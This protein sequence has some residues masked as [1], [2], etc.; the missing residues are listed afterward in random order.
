[1]P[2]TRDLRPGQVTGAL[3]EY[4]AALRYEEVLARALVTTKRTLLDTIMVA[5][6]GSS[7]PGVESTLELLTNEGG[8]AESSAWA[9]GLRLPVCSAA[10]LNALCAA[11]LDYD[12][13]YHGV[14]VDGVVLPAALAVAEHEH[15]SG[16][17]FLTALVAGH[18]VTCRL[19][20]AVKGRHRGWYYTSI[21]GAFGAAAAAAKLLRLDA[22]TMLHAFGLALSQAS[23][24]QQS[25][26]ERTLAMRFQAAFAARAGALSAMLSARGV[27]APAQSMEGRFGLFS[28]YQS[29]DLARVR[30]GLG[31]RYAS[32]EM[33]LKK[34]PCCA[35]SHAA[36]EGALSLAREHEIRPE[37]FVSA[38]VFIS[39]AMRRLVGG[40]FAPGDAPQVAAQFSVQYGVACALFRKRFGILDIRDDVVL[41]PEMQAFA[42]RITVAV[43]KSLTGK[44]APAR[45]EIRL[46]D[47]GVIK[48]MIK[49]MPGT[50][51]APLSHKAIEAKYHEC[52]RSGVL[53]MSEGQRLRLV[54]RIHKLEHLSDVAELPPRITGNV[55]YMRYQPLLGTHNRS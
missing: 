5:W 21:F 48:K 38:R 16:R 32:A 55:P 46:R 10:F 29:G 24:T 30:N 34:Y 9:Y 52:A 51:R 13:H 41:E 25:A 50:L 37:Q 47:R 3:A 18:E 23:G 19:A 22:A 6:A 49:H 11:A 12:S 20:E 35:C 31:T 39:P 4:V 7:A 2:A 45:V 26:T 44:F 17:D 43:E 28:L 53:P 40:P 33:S 15:S 27:T 42:K 14:H 54:R 36:I 1:M 8:I